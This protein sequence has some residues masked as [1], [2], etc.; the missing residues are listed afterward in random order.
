MP[1]ALPLKRSNYSDMAAE[2]VRTMIVNQELPEGERINEVHLSS[3]LGV[4]R[5]PL[6]EALNRLASEGA[7]TK[8][9]N[10]GYFVKPLTLEEFEPLYEMR[11]ILDPA[12]LRLAGLPSAETLSR[13]RALNQK[14]EASRRV[15]QTLDLDEQW[16]L[17][18]VGACPNPIL[19]DLIKQFICRTRRYEIAVMHERREVLAAGSNHRAVLAALQRRDLDGA[20][21]ALR[22]NLIRGR[23]PIVEWLK[24]RAR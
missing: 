18:L 23:A 24:T 22:H 13:L 9:S 12:A 8:T 11:A 2:A 4:S 3:R 10:F 19:L 6:R 7:L 14:I 21:E 15:S 20:C 16:H 5:T 17:E 1:V